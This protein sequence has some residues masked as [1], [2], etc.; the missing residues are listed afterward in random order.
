VDGVVFPGWRELK[1]GGWINVQRSTDLDCKLTLKPPQLDQ[2]VCP[3]PPVPVSAGSI[4][5]YPGPFQPSHDEVV[6][7]EVL[8]GDVGVM[9]NPGQDRGG[10]QVLDL[11]AGA[12]LRQRQQRT[13][14]ARKVDLPSESQL[15]VLEVR[16]AHLKVR[17]TVLVGWVP[18][19]PAMAWLQAQ[20]RYKLVAPLTR[21]LHQPTG[22][23]GVQ[24]QGAPGTPVVPCGGT[25]KQG[26]LRKVRYPV[27]PAERSRLTGWAAQADLGHLRDGVC[28]LTHALEALLEECPGTSDFPEVLGK[29]AEA[30]FLDLPRDPA[31][32]RIAHDGDGKAWDQVSLPGGQAGWTKREEHQVHSIFDWPRWDR[33]KEPGQYERDGLC[34]AEKLLK[35][36]DADHDGRISVSEARAAIRRFRNL[37]CRFPSEWMKAGDRFERIKSPPWRCSEAEYQQVVTQVDA[38]AWWSAL[39]QGVLKEL[40]ADGQDLTWHL[41][42]VGF[43]EQLAGL[44]EGGARLD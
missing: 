2:V 30:Q 34:D 5:G 23:V 19:P 8:T 41:H 10:L 28:T 15:E 12:E 42:P 16:G 44:L 3:D 7:V 36:I 18:G 14:A 17:A 40:R 32:P 25:D 37:A 26:T 13:P 21:L 9:D 35:L 27:G 1:G 43:L 39:P 4:L 31:D 22:E 33:V 38:L 24:V 6:H 20:K 11:P 29:T